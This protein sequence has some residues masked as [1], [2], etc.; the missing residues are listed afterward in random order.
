VRYKCIP[1]TS[2]E[3][4]EACGKQNPTGCAHLAGAAASQL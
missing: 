4:D 3:V 1:G 2:H